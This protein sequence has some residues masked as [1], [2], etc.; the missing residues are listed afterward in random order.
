MRRQIEQNNTLPSFILGL[1][2]SAILFVGVFTPLVS[3]PIIG[4]IYYF[5]NGHGDGVVILVLAGISVV[6]SLLKWYRGLWATGLASLALLAFTFTTFQLGMSQFHAAAD[7][8]F[9]IA[10]MREV[11]FESVQLQWGWAVLVVGGI[12]VVAAAAAAEVPRQDKYRSLMPI[13]WASTVPT[14]MGLAALLTLAVG[15]GPS[16]VSH[17][18]GAPRPHPGLGP[19]ASPTPPG[20][21]QPDQLP[22]SSW[23]PPDK[24]VQLGDLQI[25]VTEVVIGKVPL[26][27]HRTSEDTHLI[28]RLYLLN[29]SP[30]KKVEYRSWGGEDFSFDRDHA[31]CKDNFGNSYYRREF[32]LFSR[33]VGAAKG[34]ESIYPN[35]SVTDVLVFEVPVSKVTYLDLELSASNY[36]SEGTVR[37]RIPVSVIR[38]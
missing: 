3:T 20:G 28:V 13:A 12:L 17:I 2:G 38:R 9:V 4:T 23:A 33:P 18:T 21:P 1:V 27:G 24:A 25:Q 32:G 31:T 22:D 14:V 34:V 16:L 10:G 15:G 35:K 36:G 5:Y 30:T 29:T 6:L 37:F 26:E 11:M 19:M 7:D 8:L